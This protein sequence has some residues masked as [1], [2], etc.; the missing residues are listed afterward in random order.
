MGRELYQ[1]SNCGTLNVQII[2]ILLK[3]GISLINKKYFKNVF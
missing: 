1:L 2:L 3:K